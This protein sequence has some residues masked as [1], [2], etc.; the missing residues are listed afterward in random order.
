MHE[1]SYTYSQTQQ[2]SREQQLIYL[3]TTVRYETQSLHVV[4]NTSQ[5]METEENDDE[6]DV[7]DGVVLSWGGDKTATVTAAGLLH[8]P[9]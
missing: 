8:N 2:S 5:L 3:S 9:S 4:M 6:G 7:V 1:T